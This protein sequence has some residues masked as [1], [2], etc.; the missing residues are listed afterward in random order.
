MN[1][2]IIA[3]NAAITL[4]LLVE[5][6]I[7]HPINHGSGVTGYLYAYAAINGILFIAAFVR[8]KH[9]NISCVVFLTIGAATCFV[10]DR[11]NIYTDYDLWLSR[12][13]PNWGEVSN[14]PK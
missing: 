3:C 10:I 8:S 1:K 5:L 9:P 13:M 2:I 12:G 7:R 4:L 6:W 14:P 11:Y